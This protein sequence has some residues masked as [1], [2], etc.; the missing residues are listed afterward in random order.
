MSEFANPCPGGGVIIDMED[1][2]DGRA[3]CPACEQTIAVAGDRL[4]DHSRTPPP[5]R[6]VGEAPGWEGTRAVHDRM[7][8]RMNQR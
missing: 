4:T 3:F 2:S 8:E 1:V 7:V 6:V 5:R